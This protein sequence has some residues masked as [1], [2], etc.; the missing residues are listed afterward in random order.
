MHTLLLEN[1]GWL[2]Q[3]SAAMAALASQADVPDAELFMS[4]LEASAT[5][6]RIERDRASGVALGIPGTPGVLVNDRLLPGIP[7][8]SYLFRHVSA[9]FEETGR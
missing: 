2:V 3:P 7:D 5:A 6:D 4:C 1:S 9:A 8:S